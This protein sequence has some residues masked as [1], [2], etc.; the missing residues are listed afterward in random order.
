MSE[1]DPYVTP[2]EP[3]AA[4]RVQAMFR[5]LGVSVAQVATAAVI[6]YACWTATSIMPREP[7]PA[8]IA[9]GV[10][11]VLAA[12]VL[13][14]LGAMIVGLLVAQKLRLANWGAYSLSI[15]VVL[16]VLSINLANAG[17]GNYQI[18]F[19]VPTAVNLLIALSAG[20]QRDRLRRS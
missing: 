6:A 10:P 7:G 2:E 11:Y 18:V 14:P 8:D 4:P 17:S 15:I 1:A 3:A 16:V 20:M 13:V 19:L 9:D 5:S 12:I